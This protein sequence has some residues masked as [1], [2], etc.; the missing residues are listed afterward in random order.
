[1]GNALSVSAVFSPRDSLGCSLSRLDDDRRVDAS[2]MSFYRKRAASAPPEPVAT[3]ATSRGYLLGLSLAGGHRRRIFHAHHSTVHDFAE[4]AVYLRS[5]QD[6][7]R[8]ELAGSFDFA[9]LEI[10]PCAIERLADSADLAGVSEL[11]AFGKESDPVLGG[12]MGALFAPTS[13]QLERSALFVDQLSLAI[14]IH[15]THRYGNA[16]RKTVTERAKGRRLSPRGMAAVQD[17]MRDRLHG[18][19]AIK[20]LA[21]ACSLSESA[22]LRAFRETTGKTP[23]QFLIQ[24]RVEKA[25]DLLAFSSLTL[26]EI[27]AACGFADQS[28]FSRIFSRIVGTAPGTWRRHRKA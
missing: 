11:Q 27:A 12:L 1:M 10:G 17:M 14:G 21:R 24:E 25:R 2:G 16:A 15:V 28:H 9:L 3:P 5:F 6:A 4:N 13:D 18:D 7:Y 8:A 23:H 22:F 19:I 20:D 26:S